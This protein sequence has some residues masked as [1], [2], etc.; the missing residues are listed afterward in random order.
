M[1]FFVI[2]K[3]SKLNF[4]KSYRTWTYVEVSFVIGI[5]TPSQ[6]L[7]PKES[8]LKFCYS[9]NFF[10]SSSLMFCR[11]ASF[12]FIC[13]QFKNISL[14]CCSLSCFVSQFEPLGVNIFKVFFFPVFLM[15]V[16]WSNY[17][18]A[19]AFKVLSLITVSERKGLFPKTDLIP[20]AETTFKVS[21]LK[22]ENL[23]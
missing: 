3:A 19:A 11:T 15:T 13:S 16:N 12:L 9:G 10:Q 20:L 22:L 6:K 8:R 1:I 21:P 14:V 18:S 2:E 7:G 4:S 5:P 23:L 17:M